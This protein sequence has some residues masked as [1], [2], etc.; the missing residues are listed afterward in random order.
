MYGQTA[1]ERVSG[2]A[3]P[4]REKPKAS[5][6]GGGVYEEVVQMQNIVK[7]FRRPEDGE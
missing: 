2:C 6:A 7:C 4:I 5:E 1:L 3:V